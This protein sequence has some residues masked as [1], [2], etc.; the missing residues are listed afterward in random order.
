MAMNRM[1]DGCVI[2]PEGGKDSR[3]G[4]VSVAG[5]VC[6]PLP[7]IYRIIISLVWYMLHLWWHTD[8]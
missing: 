5:P 1:A 7:Q 8:R 2:A 3:R 4:L 6:L